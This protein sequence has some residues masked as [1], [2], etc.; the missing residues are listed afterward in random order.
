MLRRANTVD[1][2]PCVVLDPVFGLYFSENGTLK[3]V[4]LGRNGREY[5][6]NTLF[7]RT[8]SEYSKLF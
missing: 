7:Q 2:T 4:I 6:V 3:L 5:W 1:S 8:K